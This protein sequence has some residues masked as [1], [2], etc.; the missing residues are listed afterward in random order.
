MLTD[1][2]GRVVYVS[3]D[4]LRPKLVG[5]PLPDRRV[6]EEGGKAIYFSDIFVNEARD[7]TFEIYCVAPVK[8]LS[9]KFIGEVVTEIDMSPSKAHSG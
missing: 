4:A 7:K 1:Q 5:K 8:G 3:N 6:Y 2:H 9:G